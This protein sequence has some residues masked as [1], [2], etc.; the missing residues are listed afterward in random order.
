MELD[1]VVYQGN[2]EDYWDTPVTTLTTPITLTLRLADDVAASA[3][4][5]Y[6]IREHDGNY[7]QAETTF[8]ATDKTITFKTDKFSNYAI[9]KG[10]PAASGS[11][12]ASSTSSTGSSG[13]NTPQTGDADKTL[14]WVLSAIASALVAAYA[15]R[16]LK[17]V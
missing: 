11:S 17:K 4:S 5:F 6:I 14:P 9:V 13:S 15:L 10:A 3:S 1:K 8:N 2:D 7:Q 16:Q 12:T